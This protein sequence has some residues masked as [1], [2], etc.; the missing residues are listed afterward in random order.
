MPLPSTNNNNNKT[1][2]AISE[3]HRSELQCSGGKLCFLFSYHLEAVHLS[4]PSPKWDSRQDR[5]WWLGI[6]VWEQDCLRQVLA[7]LLIP[8]RP[9]QLI[10]RPWASVTL[11]GKQGWWYYRDPEVGENPMKGWGLE[12]CVWPTVENQFVLKLLFLCQLW[13][14]PLR[15]GLWPESLRERQGDPGQGQVGPS[16]MGWLTPKMR[17]KPWVWTQE[18]QAGA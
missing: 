11:A 16:M 8:V 13:S 7:L 10:L 6:D 1:K 15:A 12:V 17:K 14:R 2:F 3:D 4:L 5:V 9:K 18:S